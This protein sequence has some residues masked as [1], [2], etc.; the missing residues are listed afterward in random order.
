MQVFLELLLSLSLVLCQQGTGAQWHRISAD[1]R[2]PGLGRTDCQ[3][4]VRHAVVVKAMMA[5]NLPQRCTGGGGAAGRTG[6]HVRSIGG[7]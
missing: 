1:T 5:V 2:G 7:L 3:C 6:A 4:A